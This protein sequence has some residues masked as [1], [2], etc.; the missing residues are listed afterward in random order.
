[1]GLILFQYVIFVY[2]YNRV[3]R[4]ILCF[5]MEVSSVVRIENSLKISN[6]NLELTYNGKQLQKGLPYL[7]YLNNSILA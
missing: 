7:V 5:E 4:S 1:M 3:H 6:K 2:V